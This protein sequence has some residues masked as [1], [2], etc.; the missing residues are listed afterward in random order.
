MLS[1]A[2]RIYSR[3]F[4]DELVRNVP[5]GEE[6]IVGGEMEVVGLLAASAGPDDPIWCVVKGISDFADKDRDAIFEQS[7]AQACRNAAEFILSA[8]END[9][10]Q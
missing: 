9:V 6:P 8:L 10:H 2:A 4:R 7:R 3:C 5:A 1:G